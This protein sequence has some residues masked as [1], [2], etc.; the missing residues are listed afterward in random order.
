M[1]Q[2]QTI[3]DGRG[4]GGRGQLT[5]D[6]PFA[7]K[8]RQR[9]DQMWEQLDTRVNPDDAPPRFLAELRIYRGQDRTWADQSNTSDE[10]SPHG[11][12]VSVIHTG[13]RYND[14]LR[15]DGLTYQSPAT[16]RPGHDAAEIAAAKRAM[17]LD[18]PVFVITPGIT[19][20]GRQVRRG[21]ITRC[22]ESARSVEI[23]FQ[24]A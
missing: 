13:K 17:E 3:S 12:T 8:E 4:M 20:K 9:R 7:A 11:V 6:S 24:S 23:R 2:R 21:N 15:S 10:F 22:D 5:M 14:E 18:L 1:R 16:G 19:P